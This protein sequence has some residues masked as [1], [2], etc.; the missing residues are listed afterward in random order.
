MSKYSSNNNRHFLKHTRSK[1][2]PGDVIIVGGIHG[3]KRGKHGRVYQAYSHMSDKVLGH[4][5]R[6][7]GIYAGKGKVIDSD[8]DHSGVGHRRLSHFLKDRKNYKI[9][10]PN[11]PE[12]KRLKA[13]KFIKKQVGKGYQ[14]RNLAGSLWQSHISKKVPGIFSGGKS[15]TCSG[16]AATAYKGKHS[17]DGRK[18]KLYSPLDL[19]NDSKNFTVSHKGTHTFKGKRRVYSLNK[20]SAFNQ[21]VKEALKNRITEF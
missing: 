7:V 17:D 20:H 11:V 9:L 3:E 2:T 14:Y 16:L 21:K 1:L 8:A 5:N 19:A 12:E 10:K 18:S 6:H 4:E 15:F 13:L